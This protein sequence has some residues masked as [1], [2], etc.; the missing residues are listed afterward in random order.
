MN[1]V[2]VSGESVECG[3]TAEYAECGVPVVR[4]RYRHRRQAK[5]LLT[6]PEVHVNIAQA[7]EVLDARGL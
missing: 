5:T 3:L 7:S 4:Y 1:L 2:V 6:W